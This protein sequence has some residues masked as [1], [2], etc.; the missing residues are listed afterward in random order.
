M[1]RILFILLIFST[2]LKGQELWQLQPYA[3]DSNYVIGAMSSGEPFWIHK[4]SLGI[5][6]GGGGSIE[7]NGNTNKVSYWASSDSLTHDTLFSYLPANDRLGI[8]INVP[9]GL[10]VGLHLNGGTF[11]D[12]HLTNPSTGTASS[13]GTSLFINGTNTF[14]TNRENGYIVLATQN[15]ER[16]RIDEDGILADDLKSGGTAPTTSG[17]VVKLVS[18]ANGRIS[19][20][21]NNTGTV[22]SV[23]LTTGTTGTDIN[24]SGSPVTG[25]GSFTLNIPTASGSNTGKLSSTDWTTFNNKASGS[26]VANKVAFWSGTNT[27]SSNTVFHWDNTNGRLG[28]NNVAPSFRLD[29]SDDIRVNEQRIGKGSGNI[30]TNLVF[31]NG[32]LSANTTG[33]QNLAIGFA[34]LAACT[35]GNGNIALGNNTIETALTTGTNNVAIGNLAM[36]NAGNVSNNIAIGYQVFRNVTGSNN[37]GV[38]AGGVTSGSQNVCINQGV[39]GVT[40]GSQNILI[41]ME[42]GQSIGSGSTNVVIGRRAGWSSSNT[43]G[44]ILIGNLAGFS[45]TVGNRLH[46]TNDNTTSNGIYGNFSNGRFGINTAPSSMT[47]TWDINGDLRV[48]NLITTTPVWLMGADNDGVAS[49][50]TLGTGL[51]LT[52]NT[53]NANV[54]DNDWGVFSGIMCNWGVTGNPATFGSGLDVGIGTC[55][56]TRDLDVNG[57]V[58]LRG[59]IYNSSNS[60]GTSGQVLT[61][62]GS[63]AF[64]W[65]DKASEQYAQLFSNSANAITANSSATLLTAANFGTLGYT[66]TTGFTNSATNRIRCDFT[67]TVKIQ[68]DAV[69]EGGNGSS[70]NHNLMVYKNGSS[71]TTLPS[72]SAA[73]LALSG[74]QRG[75]QYYKNGIIVDV[76]ANDYF[77]FYYT[78]PTGT[79]LV[80]PL[81]TIQR[82]K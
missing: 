54:G 17:T 7:G 39:T 49:R 80:L 3:P 82:I 73:G 16:I 51:S 35:T 5:S 74:S 21:A 32:A 18:D 76:T 75:Q 30:G 44:S 66:G 10:G 36:Q 1:I 22:T 37:I 77:E 11:T 26:G 45:E 70:T 13:D 71:G 59:A 67:G 58:R 50:C 23:G 9:T 8:G 34:S 12:I 25:S 57:N 56:P 72:L 31:G 65:A 60:A 24:V 42:A 29:V 53:I 61:S 69:W 48:R 81:I 15:I 43:S 40:T 2:Q 78:C 14:L 64:V 55:S 63:S 33:F 79:T 68:I 19:F 27:L 41:G 62:Q 38:G 4:D 20:Q 28:L 6:G 47:R 52:G 46:I